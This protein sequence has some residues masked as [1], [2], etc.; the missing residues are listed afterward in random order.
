MKIYDFISRPYP[1]PPCLRVQYGGFYGPAFFSYF[2]DQNRLIE[3][4]KHPVSNAKALK[5]GT[6]GLLDACI[7]V[8]AMAKG[9]PEFAYNNTFGIEAYPEEVYNEVMGLIEAP[10]EGCVALIDGCRSL[11]EEGDP[12]SFGLNETVNAACLAATDVCF[13]KVQGALQAYS[14]VS[15]PR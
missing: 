14:D 1:D 3:D 5:L 2:A 8:K 15:V 12:Q 9:Y 4:G 11:A 6:L 7:D 10:E 13:N